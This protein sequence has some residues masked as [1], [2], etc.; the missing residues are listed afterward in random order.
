MADHFFAI[1]RGLEG[2]SEVLKRND[3]Q[4]LVEKE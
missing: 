3:V 1:N 4:T 2:F